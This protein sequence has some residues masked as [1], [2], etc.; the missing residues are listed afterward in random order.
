ME[1]L[2]IGE[3]VLAKFPFSDLTSQ[4]LRPCLIIGLAEFDDV[5]LCQ[6]TSKRYGSNRAV[7]LSKKDF[8]TG[9]LVVESFVRPDKIATLDVNMLER[10]LGMLKEAKIIEVKAALRK[11]LD[12]EG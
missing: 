10:S 2:S 8:S 6:I 4:K 3:V 11:V 5:V 1:S 9:S 7:Q 12:I